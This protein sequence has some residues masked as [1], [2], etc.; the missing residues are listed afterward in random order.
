MCKDQ[1]ITSVTG[2]YLGY[3]NI[4]NERYW[5]YRYVK[6]YKVRSVFLKI[7]D[8]NRGIGAGV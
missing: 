7:V 1:K 8:K 5:D 6:P 4:G 2:T 3:I